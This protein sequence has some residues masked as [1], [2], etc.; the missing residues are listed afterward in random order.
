MCAEGRWH[1]AREKR[2]LRDCGPFLVNP[3]VV[4]Y[5][6]TDEAVEIARVLHRRRNLPKAFAKP[7]S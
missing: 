1:G 5:R 3:Y 7:E 2:S 4:F 6:V